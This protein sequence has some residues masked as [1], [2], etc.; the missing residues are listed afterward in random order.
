MSVQNDR[1]GELAAR[2]EELLQDARAI[3]GVAAALAVFEEASR[4][5]PYVPPSTPQVQF[6]ASTNA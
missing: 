6:S 4:R 1:S 3:A 5:A 2:R